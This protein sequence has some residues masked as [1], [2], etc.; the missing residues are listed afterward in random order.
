MT[1]IWKTYEFAPIEEWRSKMF[2]QGCR[3]IFVVITLLLALQNLTFCQRKMPVLFWTYFGIEL[4]ALRIL[5]WYLLLQSILLV[6][7]RNLPSS[8]TVLLFLIILYIRLLTYL[9]FYILLTLL[10]KEPGNR[11]CF[12][13][14]IEFLYDSPTYFVRQMRWLYWKLFV[15][16]NLATLWQMSQCK[17]RTDT[18]L[19]SLR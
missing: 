3:Y 4:F 19:L 18:L 14:L 5:L 12:S 2:F 11:F 17:D 16:F 15:H 9:F 13:Y 6:A 1:H 8:L 7:N 10:I